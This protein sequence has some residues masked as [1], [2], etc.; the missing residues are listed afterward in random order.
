M[1][2]GSGAAPGLVRGGLQQRHFTTPVRK[3]PVPATR[4]WCPDSNGVLYDRANY[5]GIRLGRAPRS[6]PL[7][8]NDW[9]GRLFMITYTTLGLIFVPNG[10]PTS[11]LATTLPLLMAYPPH[12]EVV[13]SDKK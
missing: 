12:R 6:A 9:S 8:T 5:M 2:T 3:A 1:P 4:R 10:A 11:L 7:S 13:A